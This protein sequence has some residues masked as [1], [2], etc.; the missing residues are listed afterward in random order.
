LTNEYPELMQQILDL[1]DLNKNEDLTWI[2]QTYD[3]GMYI[4]QT[5]KSK[6]RHGR[7][8]Y[9]WTDS[10]Y[11]IGYWQNSTKQTY[12]RY[13]NA[14]MSLFYEGEVKDG[15]KHGKGTY[16]FNNG[17][18]TGQFVNDIREGPGTYYWNDGTR[19]EG[20]CVNGQLKGV[21]TQYYSDGSSAQAE[22]S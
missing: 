4:G 1:A 21:G 14:N 8:A 20:Q 9:Y 6:Q 19:W 22:F 12:A 15:M 17:Y 7:G 10:Q 5:D 11:Y 13:L 3:N 18:Y 16:Y 2:K